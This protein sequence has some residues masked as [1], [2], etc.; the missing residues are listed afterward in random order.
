MIRTLPQIMVAP[1]G[2]RRTKADH[3][4]LPMSIPEIVATARKCFQAGAGA[5]HAHVR[6]PEK[7]THVLDAALYK[8]LIIA[9]KRAVPHMM[10][11]ISTE[12]VGQYLPPEQMEMVRRTLPEAASI[13]LKELLPR[14][15]D[16]YGAL[17]FYHWC[18]NQHIAV[19]HILYDA[20]D[21]RRLASLVKGNIIPS[22]NLSVL[23]VLGRYS[24]NLES[25]PSDLASFL[26][27]AKLFHSPPDWMVCA[28]GQSETDALKATLKA[29]GKVRVGF[30]NSLYNTQG[31][32]APS[33]E[34]RVAEIKKINEELCA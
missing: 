11:Q 25:E 15:S 23:Y 34:D 12:A 29:G 30:E 10:V 3:P 18:T 13:A 24:K 8:E 9:L 6:H 4:E 31:E 32:R 2:A 33:N 14:E 20:P 26:E 16:E 17:E 19:Q 5:I 28:F 27:A 7:G 21:V 22:E 1:N